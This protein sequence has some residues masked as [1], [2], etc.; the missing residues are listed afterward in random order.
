MKVFCK[1]IPSFLLAIARHAQSTK[2]K[3]ALSLQHLKKEGSEEL[4]FLHADDK[5][6]YVL[7]VGTIKFGGHGQSCP[8][9]PKQQV[10]I[11]L[12]YLKIEER[13]E[14]DFLCR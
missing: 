11:I 14:V 10:A 4:D 3:F 5:H 1:L 7:Q 13:D 2:N 9:Y 12:Q 8:K 6:Q